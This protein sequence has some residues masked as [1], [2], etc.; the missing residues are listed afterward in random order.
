MKLD[1]YNVLYQLYMLIL[2]SINYALILNN[3]YYIILS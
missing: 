3:K 1:Y 2:R